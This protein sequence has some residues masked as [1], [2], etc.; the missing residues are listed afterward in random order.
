MPCQKVELFENQYFFGCIP[1]ELKTSFYILNEEGWQTTC[2]DSVEINLKEV[3][4][5]VWVQESSIFIAYLPPQMYF[6]SLHSIKMM[7]L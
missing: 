3:E 7:K 6:D 4:K 2:Q 5:Y 1:L